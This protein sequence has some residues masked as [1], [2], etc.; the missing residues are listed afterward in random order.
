MF[1]DGKSP[2][3]QDDIVTIL[4]PMKGDFYFCPYDSE[5]IFSLTNRIVLV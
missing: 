3:S 1:L 4:V 5:F 2:Y